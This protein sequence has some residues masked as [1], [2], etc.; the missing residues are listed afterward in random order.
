MSQDLWTSLGLKA[1]GAGV[2][3]I[4]A[5][6]IRPP[7]KRSEF[8]RR[9]LFSFLFGVAMVP[10]LMYYLPLAQNGESL[11]ALAGIVAFASWFVGDAV[12]KSAPAIAA[13]LIGF[14]S[15]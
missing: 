13:K 6:L 5:L 12:V 8:W 14:F 15:R 2:G 9:L 10:V 1:I 4:L 11:V 3:S 7:R